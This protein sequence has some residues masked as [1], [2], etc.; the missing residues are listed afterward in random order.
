VP[1]HEFEQWFGVLAPAKTPRAIV[2]QLSKEV[3]RIVSLPDVKERIVQLGSVPKPST[4]EEFDAFIRAEVQK[5]AKVVKAA[6][7]RVE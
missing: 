4:P 5:L 1:G 6:N 2:N 3:A 7:I